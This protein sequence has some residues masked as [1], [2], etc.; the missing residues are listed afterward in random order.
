MNFITNTLAAAALAASMTLA[1]AADPIKI[2][3]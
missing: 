3:G 1:S 2:G